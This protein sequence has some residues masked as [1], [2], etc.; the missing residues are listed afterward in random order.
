MTDTKRTDNVVEPAP[1]TEMKLIDVI[2]KLTHNFAVYIETS[3]IDLPNLT[4]LLTRLKGGDPLYK[5]AFI[6]S[7]I[8][9]RADKIAALIDDEIKKHNIVVAQDKVEKCLRYI[10]ALID[11]ASQ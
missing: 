7:Q 4:L 8:I 1:T 2:Q 11:V 9:P 3:G 10:D 5:L 6:K